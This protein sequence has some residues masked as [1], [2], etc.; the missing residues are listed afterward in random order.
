MIFHDFS[1]ELITGLQRSEL[2]R[3]ADCCW[4][5]YG[6]R[7]YGLKLSRSISIKNGDYRG[8]IGENNLGDFLFF[9]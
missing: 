7:V 2:K 6:N 3:A 5:K 4:T 8:P 9:P 1:W